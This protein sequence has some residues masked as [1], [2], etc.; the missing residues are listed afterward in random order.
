M[1]AKF[2]SPTIQQSRN[3]LEN[4]DKAIALGIDL[5]ISRSMEWEKQEQVE[6]L[7]SL[8]QFDRVE[9]KLVSFHMQMDSHSNFATKE[10]AANSKRGG[11]ILSSPKDIFSMLFQ[12]G[13]EREGE[14][15]M[16][17]GSIG[18]LAPVGAPGTFWCIEDTPTHCTTQPGPKTKF[19]T[20]TIHSDK[21]ITGCKK[22]NHNL[23]ELWLN[24]EQKYKA[25]LVSKN[26]GKPGSLTQCSWED[27][28][29]G[30]SDCRAALFAAVKN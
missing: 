13:G 20:F 14:T 21:Y 26:H 16:R 19:Y 30:V 11:G 17:E 6:D 25:Q 1:A 23:K 4:S 29:E 27:G 8:I 22:A 28:W 24:R 2:L 12:R 18:H 9:G 3:T 15:S 5:G 10:I 7:E